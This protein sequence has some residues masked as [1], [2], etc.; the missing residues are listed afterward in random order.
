M[1]RS[2]LRQVLIREFVGFDTKKEAVLLCGE[3]IEEYAYIILPYCEHGSIIDLL[4]KA[5]NLNRKISR[6]LVKYLFCNTLLALEE[7]LRLSGL[8]HCDIK[9]DNLVID[10]NFL[11]KLIDY[12]HARKS[13]VPTN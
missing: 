10:R 13:G 4:V 9:P 7:L 3:L 12:G 8:S 6:S 11:I 2:S 5:N 1:D